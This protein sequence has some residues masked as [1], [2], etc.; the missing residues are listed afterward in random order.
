MARD[1]AHELPNTRVRGVHV[2]RLAL[3][4]VDADGVRVEAVGDEA[5]AVHVEDVAGGAVG[6]DVPDGR[7]VEAHFVGRVVGEDVALFGALWLVAVPCRER[8]GV[9][10][11][12]G[13]TYVQRV[14]GWRSRELIRAHQVRQL[15]VVPI[16]ETTVSGTSSPSR[17]HIPRAGETYTVALPP[18]LIGPSAP[19]ADGVGALTGPLEL[20]AVAVFSTVGRPWPL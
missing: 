14:E 17:G 10:V 3:A 19:L 13:W 18:L 2:Q 20:M 16:R 1:M 8:C 6:V 12:R 9:C 5:V 7:V 11:C 4:V 15:R